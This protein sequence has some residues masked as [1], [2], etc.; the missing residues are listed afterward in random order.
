MLIL[1]LLHPVPGTFRTWKVRAGL[2]QSDHRILQ[3][4]LGSRTPVAPVRSTRYNTTKANW[5]LFL[6]LF[7]DLY[8]QEPP[9]THNLQDVEALAQSLTTDIQL[10]AESTTPRKTIFSR[11]VPWWTAHLTS[12]KKRCNRMR[13]RLQRLRDPDERDN[14]RRRY[15][16]LRR[17]Y[18]R[19]VYRAKTSSWHTFVTELGNQDPYGIVYKVV[20]R[21][22]AVDEVMA[23]FRNQGGR[24]L[25]WGASARFLLSALIPDAPQSIPS[26]NRHLL[27]S[28]HAH[29]T[30]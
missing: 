15:A 7:E 1:P 14:L 3:I 2:T 24:T 22:L 10:C 18:S 11:S 8:R 5:A 30:R 29:S 9:S 25:T 26:Q 4:T 27:P 13:R 28:R 16:Q 19:S 20:R 23:D 17:F 12:L 21:R 6:E